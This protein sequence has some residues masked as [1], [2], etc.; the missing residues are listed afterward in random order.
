MKTGTKLILRFF[1]DIEQTPSS[2]IIRAFAAGIT[3]APPLAVVAGGR[4][5]HLKK[6]A[7]RIACE[8]GCPLLSRELIT[9]VIKSAETR[10][11]L[12]FVQVY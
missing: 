7:V 2:P 6:T 1:P 12:N 10:A 8:I 5:S 11:E 9:R 4:R 3:T